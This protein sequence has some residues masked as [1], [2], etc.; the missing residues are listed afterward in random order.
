MVRI[1]SVLSTVL[2]AGWALAGAASE[3]NAGHRHGCCRSKTIYRD[4]TRYRSTYH[5]NYVQ[6]YHRVERAQWIQPVTR[7]HV[8][9]VIH[10]RT[11]PVWHNV[12]VC[13]PRWLPP[14]VEYVSSRTIRTYA[15]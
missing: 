11:V 12:I 10:E 15:Y 2:I 13:V 9:N 8:V 6:R 14:R 4:V 1:L 3:A 7:V 5:T